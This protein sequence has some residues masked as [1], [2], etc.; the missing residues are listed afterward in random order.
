MKNPIVITLLTFVP[1]SLLSL[2]RPAWITGLFLLIVVAFEMKFFMGVSLK[3]RG[4]VRLGPVPYR[5][6]YPFFPFAIGV[7]SYGAIALGYVASNVVPLVAI[8]AASLIAV[9]KLWLSI[10]PLWPY[11]FDG[12]MA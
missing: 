11:S 4:L 1:I 5:F 7:F 10:G 8:C 9:S 3:L 2:L 6:R 12:E